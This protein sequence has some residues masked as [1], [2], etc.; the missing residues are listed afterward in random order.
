MEVFLQGQLDPWLHDYA[1]DSVT[2][3]QVDFHGLR[4]E[5][6]KLFEPT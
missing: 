6:L 4:H 5:R 3:G 1:L 2:C